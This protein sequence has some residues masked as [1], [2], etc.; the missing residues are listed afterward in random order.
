VQ[1]GLT[2][3]P[4]RKDN[5]DTYA[6]FGEP[7]YIYSL[8]DGINDSFLTPF[9]VKQIAT[10]LDDY[11]YTPDDT[12]VEGEIEAGK[13]YTEPDFNRIIEIGPREKKHRVQADHRARYAAIRRQGLLHDLRFCAGAPSFQRSGVGRRADGAGN[14]PEMRL[15][16]VRM[17]K[18][19]ESE[20][21]RR[22]GAD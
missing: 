18:E 15:S 17:Q 12:L 16:P 5:M 3:T 1:L 4:K 8:K 20:A 14:L 2:A 10:T 7:V 11:V 6:Y 13:R 19:G 9:R 21:S 22:Q